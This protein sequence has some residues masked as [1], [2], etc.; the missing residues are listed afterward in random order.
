VT[1]GPR[2]FVLQPTLT[3][4]RLELR[5][6]RPDDFEALYS[7]ARDPL[8]WAVHPEPN[9][10]ERP[11]FERFFA[12]ALKS[13]G[14]LAVVDRAAGRIVGSSRYYDLDVEKSEIIIGYTFLSR[15]HWGG[16][17][18]REMKS[19]MLD[20]AFRFVEA[21]IFHVGENNIRSR[22]A[23]EKIGGV[24]SGSLEKLGP[25]GLPRRNVV[26]RIARL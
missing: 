15:S 18:N 10:H 6:L 7:V 14:A 13:G 2:D 3:G 11:V 17:F 26:Y 19:L 21:V 22:K 16:S 20:H 12:E 4:A 1:T 24:L 25:D 5:P 23:M 9:R 8:I